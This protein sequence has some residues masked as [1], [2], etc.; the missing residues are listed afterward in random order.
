MVLML[1]VDS[2]ST[3]IDEIFENSRVTVSNC[4]RSDR[5]AWNIGSRARCAVCYRCAR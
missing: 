5:F 3:V 1:V 2:A 4:E